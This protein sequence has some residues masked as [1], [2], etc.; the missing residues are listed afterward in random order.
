[1]RYGDIAAELSKIA[2]QMSDLAEKLEKIEAATPEISAAGQGSLPNKMALTVSEA[3]ELL[4][5]SKPKMY[6]LTFR[7]DFP[8][9]RLGKKK[10]IPRDQLWEWVKNHCGEQLD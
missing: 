6:Q 7:D 8:C 5:V 9:I 3:A 10:I 4:S 2:G 1:M